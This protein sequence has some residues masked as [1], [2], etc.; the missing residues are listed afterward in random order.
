MTKPHNSF[1]SHHS[2]TPF[3]CYSKYI[4]NFLQSHDDSGSLNSILSKKK[5]FLVPEIYNNIEYLIIPKFYFLI[6]NNTDNKRYMI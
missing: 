3:P 5:T 2:Y 4:N 6:I 1:V